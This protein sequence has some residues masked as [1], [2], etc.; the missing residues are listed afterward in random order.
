MKFCEIAHFSKDKYRQHIADKNLSDQELGTE[1]YKK[2]SKRLS[3][4][5]RVGVGAAAAHLTGGGTLVSA[6]FAGRNI[7]V[8]SQKLELLEEEWAVR[9]YAPLPE[10]RLKDKIV[11]V[12]LTAATS[13]F[14]AGMD[15][16]FAMASPD[17][18]AQIIPNTE[19]NDFLI[20]NVYYGG[21]EQGATSVK[22]TVV[23]KVVAARPDDMHRSSH[24][25]HEKKRRV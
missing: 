6:A 25:G 11:P 17:Q 10:R 23:N 1:I 13:T 16:A 22:N 9:G 5:V 15:V 14:A 12:L 20:S 18:F 24:Y 4:K 21:L 7:S 2:R 8:E 19:V 3:S